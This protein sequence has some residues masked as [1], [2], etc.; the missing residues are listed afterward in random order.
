MLFVNCSRKALL[1]GLLLIST[2]CLPAFAQVQVQVTSPS[3]GAAV[4]NAF[5]LYANASSP[6]G[7]S[8]WYIYVDH[9][10]VW[11]TPGPTASI[12][13]LWQV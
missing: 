9:S 3:N 2:L 8:G 10:A 7:V 11:N 1:V 4:A 12:A 6:N 13:R 5:T